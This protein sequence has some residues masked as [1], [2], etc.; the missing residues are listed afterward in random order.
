MSITDITF[1]FVF[2]PIALCT[3]VFKPALQKYL[4]LLLSLFFYACGSPRYFFLFM[5]AV[6]INIIFGVFIEKFRE[7][8]LGKIF[9]ITGCVLN[10]AVLFYYKY[11]NFT[12]LNLNRALHTSFEA[13]QLLI[14]LG[15]SFFVFK[16][17]SYLVDIYTQKIDVG[18]NPVYAALYLSFFGQIASGPICRY[19]KF[20]EVYEE[21]RDKREI[22]AEIA[23]GGYRFTIGFIKK[24][25][26]ANVLGHVTTEV[27]ALD[28]SD[29][30]RSI[31]WLGSLCYS[32]QLY[33][34]F[35]GYSDM[36]IGIGEMFGIHCSENFDYPYMT[37][38][39]SEF[40]RRW[41]ISLSSWFRDYIYFPLGGSRVESHVR[42]YIN[43]LVVW[44]LTGIWYGANWNFIAW[45]LI[46][47]ILIAFEKTTNLPKRLKNPIYKMIY[48]AGCLL[49]INFQWVIFNATSLHH[50]VSYIKY[51]FLGG[52]D[53]VWNHRAFI[54]LQE[55]GV[56]IF[57]AVL[58]AIPIVPWLQ[59][60]KLKTR[61]RTM[62]VNVGM[63]VIMAGLFV[64]A[65]SF[66]V[67]GQN[68]PFMYANF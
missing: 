36:A 5:V 41:H 33:Y 19:G 17:I 50:G 6:G 4:L 13:K 56:I 11:Y 67:A 3:Y 43:L 16:A 32:L 60:W 55:Y 49:I 1:L 29:A 31:L 10:I 35:S 26:I 21:N 27:F 14:P 45:G 39:I 42:L 66:V 68:N 51:M 2:L 47:F 46:Y 64:W 12:V 15:I 8:N 9:L 22:F 40:W 61:A 52:G 59:K 53:T 54:L 30:T 28:P 57:T 24:V 20:Y 63:T 62:S 38:S 18:K 65:L 25:L 7:R 23:N 37:K 44:L 34:D 48:Q 58:F